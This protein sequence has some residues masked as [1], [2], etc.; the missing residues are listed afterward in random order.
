MEK[1]RKNE[2]LEEHDITR[3]LSLKKLLNLMIWEAFYKNKIN[4][5]YESLDKGKYVKIAY[6]DAKK[7]R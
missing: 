7:Q 3:F 5:F 2:L 4:T 1:K 6:D